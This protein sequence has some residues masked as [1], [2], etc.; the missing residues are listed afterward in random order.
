MLV[1]HAVGI[2]GETIVFSSSQVIPHFLWNMKVHCH[3]HKN[4]HAIFVLM[5]II[6]EQMVSHVTNVLTPFMTTNFML[7]FWIQNCILQI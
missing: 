6:L 4:P 7:P 1:V 5:F 3:V 2:F